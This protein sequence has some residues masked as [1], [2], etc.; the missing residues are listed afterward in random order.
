MPKP[1]M[2][3]EMVIAG[4]LI[5]VTQDILPYTMAAM[6]GGL[7]GLNRIGLRR[8]GCSKESVNQ[9]KEAYRLFCRNRMA[10]AEFKAWLDQ[11]SSDPY[12]KKWA[13]FIGE[14]SHRGF[15]R[16]GAAREESDD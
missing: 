8:A 13:A 4:A 5:R 9:L 6:D 16:H 14:K 7:N 3:G 2:I 11:H 12:L 15:S 10:L 1:S